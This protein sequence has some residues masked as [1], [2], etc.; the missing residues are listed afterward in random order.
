MFSNPPGKCLKR[1]SVYTCWRYLKESMKH[2]VCAK[3]NT[4][5]CIEDYSVQELEKA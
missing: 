2:K 4:H 1:F 3:L 5:Y